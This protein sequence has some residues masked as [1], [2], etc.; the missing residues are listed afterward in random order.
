MFHCIRDIRLAAVDACFDQRR[1]QQFPCGPNKRLAFQILL[2]SRLF[3]YKH[4]FG[5]RRASP[6][7]RLRASAPKIASFA[8]LS[9]LPQ[10]LK[11]RIHGNQRTWFVDTLGHT[12]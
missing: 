9:R 4:N 12:V 5:M 11:R 6:E 7:N 2:I 3:A 8:I 1:I 10:L